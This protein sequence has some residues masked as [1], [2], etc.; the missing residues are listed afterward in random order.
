MLFFD[1]VSALIINPLFNQAWEL[2]GNELLLFLERLNFVHEDFRVVIS[3]GSPTPDHN[4]MSLP[5]NLER[6]AKVRVQLFMRSVY[7]VDMYKLLAMF[8]EGSRRYDPAGQS[9]FS[10][11]EEKFNGKLEEDEL[12][13]GEMSRHIF[14]LL[15]EVV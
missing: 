6:L 5:R 12:P 11:T 2:E 8:T 9:T 7:R 4:W 14:V 10:L 13:Q 15:R 3:N 1:V